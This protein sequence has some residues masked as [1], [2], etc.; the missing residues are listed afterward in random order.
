VATV[1]LTAVCKAY[2]A[3]RAVSGLTL[4]VESGECLALLGPSGC[5]KTTTLNM[6]AGFIEPDAGEIRVAGRP[7]AGVPPHRRDTAMVFQHYALFPHLTVFDNLAFGLVMRKTARPEIAA[8]VGEA[9]ALVHLSGLERRYPR[10]LSGGQQ[11]RVALARALVV[12]PTVLLLDEPLSN[13][14]A[15]LRHEMR[16]EIVEIQKRLRITTVFVTHD[17]AEAL[18]IAD[19][20]AVMREGLVEQVDVP[21]LIYRR[22][23]T[24]FVARFIGDANFLPGRVLARDGQTLVVETDGGARVRT[25][26]DA[27]RAPGQRVVTMVRPEKVR[28]TLAPGNG[29][30]SVEA[31]LKSVAFMGSITSYQLAVGDL[32]LT[33]SLHDTAHLPNLAPGGTVYATWQAEDA[34]VLDAE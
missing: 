18:V 10:E 23:R 16:L 26:D 34:L 1:E 30:N 9:L 22:P 13:L 32:T 29:D 3:H 14:D 6:I 24:P 11:Q 4:A 25:V 17:Q 8:R 12:R 7:M 31:V 28:L 27:A 20:I 19:R 5:G 2:G 21:A 15:R 33:A